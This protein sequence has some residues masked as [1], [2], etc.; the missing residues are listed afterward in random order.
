M[1]YTFYLAA[2]AS[3]TF[4]ET[5][6]VQATIHY[7]PIVIIVKE[8][9]TEVYGPVAAFATHCVSKISK[10]YH[11]ATTPPNAFIRL[12]QDYPMVTGIVAGIFIGYYLR[13]T[14]RPQ[15]DRK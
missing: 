8:P 11:D 1:K 10:A 12:I 7:Q 4:L 15:D 14:K 5:S 3:L 6:G 2:L 9:T 13:G